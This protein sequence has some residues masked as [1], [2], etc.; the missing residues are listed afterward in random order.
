M[1]SFEDLPPDRRAVLSLLLRQRKGYDEVAAALGIASTAVH[2]RAHA[3]LAVLAPQKARGLATDERE[4]IGEY[5][6]G[7]QDEAQAAATKAQLARSPAAREWARALAVELAK[8]TADP[9]PE[10]PVEEAPPASPPT[11]HATPP[12]PMA[13]LPAPGADQSAVAPSPAVSRRGGALL[14]AGIVAVAAIAIALILSSG[15][16]KA[17]QAASRSGESSTAAQKTGAKNPKLEAAAELKPTPAGGHARGAAL[18][19]SEG[20]KR[21]LYFS[22]NGLTPTEGFSYVLWLVHSNGH[23]TA[24]G[25]TP[26]VGSEGHVAAVELLTEDP[27]SLSGIELTRETATHPSAP[28]TVVLRGHFVNG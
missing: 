17:N 28:G 13:A 27:H 15:G 22:A 14:L 7:R 9:L 3:A 12:A 16:N 21:G 26:S 11:A 5:M 8:L 4:Q 19:A 23:I 2:D 20:S 6:L 10:I 24:F 25:R 18:I 1:T